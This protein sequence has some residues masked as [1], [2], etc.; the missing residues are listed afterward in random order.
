MGYIYGKVIEEGSGKAIQGVKVSLSQGT[1][2][3]PV[4][5]T[6]TDTDGQW[7]LNS[8]A[9]ESASAA[10]NFYKEGYGDAGYSGAGW[11]NSTISLYKLETT[12]IKIPAWIWIVLIIVI[13]AGAYAYFKM[14]K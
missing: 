2:S 8:D 14:K 9:T 13:I 3:T 1:Y 5:V 7:A 6:T 10:L 11:D 12:K 4:A